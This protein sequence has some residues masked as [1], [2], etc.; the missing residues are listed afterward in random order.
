MIELFGKLYPVWTVACPPDF[1]VI[2]SVAVSSTAVSC[3]PLSILEKTVSGSKGMKVKAS[4]MNY[5]AKLIKQ[6]PPELS[7]FNIQLLYILLYLFGGP[8]LKRQDEL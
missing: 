5:G 7:G 6:P 3:S 4:S 8:A 2:I 1:D